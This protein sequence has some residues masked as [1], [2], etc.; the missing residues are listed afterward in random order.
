MTRVA[1]GDFNPVVTGE[2][3]AVSCLG[4]QEAVLQKRGDQ[5]CLKGYVDGCASGDSEEGH[6]RRGKAY[7]KSPPP[8]SGH[9][10]LAL[11]P[12]AAGCLP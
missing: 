10:V 2:E 8:N 4:R 3:E 9:S 12:W 11:G 6:S 1:G 5:V 7:A